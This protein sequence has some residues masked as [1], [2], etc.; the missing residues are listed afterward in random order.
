MSKVKAFL[1][2]WIINNLGFKIL[3][4]VLAFILWLVITNTTDPVTTRTITG[5]PVQ[6]ENEQMVLDGT[7]VYTVMSGSTAT[8]VVSGNRSVVGSL[9]ASDF[10]ATADFAE[11]SI[12]NSVPIKVEL[13][14]DKA[15]FAGSVSIT[16]KTHSMVIQ[17]ENVGD[18][19]MAVEVQ[20]YGQPPEGMI[21]EDA[22]VSP[23][24][25]TFHAPESLIQGAEKA[26]ALVNYSEITGDITLEKE[27]I[28]YNGDGSPIALDENAYLEPAKVSVK[29]TTS[30][31]KSVPIH[32]EASGTPKEGYT[33]EGVTY[34]KPTVSLRG[35]SQT[36]AG[37]DGIY[38]PTGLLDVTDAD[39]DVSIVVDISNYLPPGTTLHGD[40]GTVTIGATIV[41][42]HEEETETETTTD[43]KETETSEEETKDEV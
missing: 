12:T 17:L 33:L 29:I 42:S 5:I 30:N 8:I 3:A 23:A 38:L 6:I 28:I 39:S 34:S 35:D 24:R 27:L 37:I 10:T 9:S 21:V 36:L 25:V 11:L 18:E 20:F 19:T 43:E 7:H 22:A 16:Q 31:I 14:G 4:L 26:V 13:A 1:Q 40:T 2:K 15:R 32:L 41:R